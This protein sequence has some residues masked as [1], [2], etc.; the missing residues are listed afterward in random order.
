MVFKIKINI[1]S[2]FELRHQPFPS[3]SW[4]VNPRTERKAL[5]NENPCLV[6]NRY[7]TKQNNLTIAWNNTPYKKI[8]NRICGWSVLVKYCEG[9]A[10]VVPARKC[11]THGDT[12]F[13]ALRQIITM[14]RGVSEVI[15]FEN[16]RHCMESYSKRWSLWHVYCKS[17]LYSHCDSPSQFNMLQTSAAYRK[18][19]NEPDSMN[20]EIR[21]QGVELSSQLKRGC[22]SAPH[23]TYLYSQFSRIEPNSW[24]PKTRI[25]SRLETRSLFISHKASNDARR[26]GL[27]LGHVL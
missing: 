8:V 17:H 22:L 21:Y 5:Q 23:P 12:S 11:N 2:P 1:K 6:S 10:E 15:Y 24:Q 18:I 4:L 27:I 14:H 25:I 7:Q 26:S 20:N 13:S 16:L 3:F 9:N 19:R